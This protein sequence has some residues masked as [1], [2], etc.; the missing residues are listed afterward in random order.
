MKIALGACMLLALAGCETAPPAVPVE[1]LAGKLAGGGHF[2]LKET[3]TEGSYG[4]VFIFP[5]RH[6]SL[7]IQAQTAWG[8][9]D[10]RELKGINTIALE[11]MYIGEELKAEKLSYRTDAEKYAVLLS[12]LERG[13]IKAPEAAY[14]A[15]DCYVFEIEKEEEYLFPLPDEDSAEAFDNYLV[16]SISIDRGKTVEQIRDR[17][18]FDL[19]LS[20]NP[21]ALETYEIVYSASRSIIEIIERLEE[22]ERKVKQVS[23]LL[24]DE[25]NDAY[26][27][28]KAFYK[29]AHQRSLTMAGSVFG[30]LQKEN[31]P[32]AMIIGL[33]HTKEVTEY[34]KEKGVRYYVLDPS[35]LYGGGGW[36]DLTDTGYE[37]KMAGMPV[38][39]NEQIT[40]FFVT[41]WNTRPVVNKE[42]F[43]KE[44]HFILLTER[45]ISGIPN[46]T[47]GGLRVDRDT[48]DRD[49]PRD[50]KFKMI[51]EDGNELYLR[52]VANTGTQGR[53]S[54]S[55]KMSLA[56]MIDRL[57]AI[58]EKNLPLTERVKAYGGVI[59][60]F[61]L[62]GYT[63][64]VSPL[65]D[66]WHVNLASL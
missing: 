34:F 47:S 39:E 66:V 2:T 46:L 4:P 61:N 29:N 51:N 54:G 11:G 35:G 14:L 27:Q 37:N 19:L 8:L 15:K 64:F 53:P 22:L 52:A 58:G 20:Q 25:M 13:E 43:K 23:F 28:L 62:D 7:L 6:N 12:L 36:T 38:F 21:W 24:P 17:A 44:N 16:W 60:A 32:L 45:M 9:E 26:Q 48:L 49:N 10:L 3:N 65:Q 59:E 40:R 18:A 41:K 57:S 1:E 30:A 50:I 31:K 63:V 56:S 55:Y 33:N 42:W 5:E